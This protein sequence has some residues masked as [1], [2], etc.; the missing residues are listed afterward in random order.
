VISHHQAISSTQKEEELDSIG[1]PAVQLGRTPGIS[2]EISEDAYKQNYVYKSCTV[3]PQ[4]TSKATAINSG[5]L[6]KPETDHHTAK[7]A[8]F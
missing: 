5:F 3:I 2:E 8:H 1:S 4:K 7:K 6:R